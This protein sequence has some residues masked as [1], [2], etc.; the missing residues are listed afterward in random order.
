MARDPLSGTLACL[1]SLSLGAGVNPGLSAPLVPA[2]QRVIPRARRL[3]FDG[4]DHLALSVGAAWID[5]PSWM[6]V[7]RTG[8][9]AAVGG[10]AGVDAT[11][12]WRPESV[13]TPTWSGAETSPGSWC[14]DV[15]LEDPPPSELSTENVA[16]GPGRRDGVL[17][18]RLLFPGA[19]I[20]LIRITGPVAGAPC[21]SSSSPRDTR[22]PGSQPCSFTSPAS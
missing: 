16:C 17:V 5:Q 22:S 15:H 19:P 4:R 6:K 20:G 10:G 9:L 2:P 8:R 3:D 18:E 11:R 13:G 12:S 21:F 14:V 7:R 1:A